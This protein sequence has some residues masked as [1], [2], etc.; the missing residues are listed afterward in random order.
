MSL[1]REARS[2]I[3]SLVEEEN[4]IVLNPSDYDYSV[5]TQATPPEGSDA[6]YNTA[7]TISSNN[8]AAPY[9]GEVEVYYNRLNLADLARLADIYVHAPDV[10]STH[11]ILPS[12]NR[13]YGLNLA[14][15]DVVNLPSVQLSGYRMVTLRATPESLGWIGELEIGVVEGDLLL[16][17]HLTERTLG[18][19]NYP[20]D[21]ITRPFAHFYSYWRSFSDHYEYLK[22]VVVGD[23]I[24]LDIVSIMNDVTGDPWVGS[25]V[26]EFSLEGAEI[27]FAGPSDQY[28][29]A[30]TDYD[31]V[32]VIALDAVKCTGMSGSLILHHTE[33]PYATLGI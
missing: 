13:R 33:D 4:N 2:T 23:P 32:V 20:T 6:S 30:N 28:L 12:L 9:I 31:R 7:L 8:P 18:G 14:T 27:T 26:L 17:T 24:G 15:E 3:L 16:E 19:L 29:G 22:E 1:Y 11:A 10:T 25:G 5:P 21:D